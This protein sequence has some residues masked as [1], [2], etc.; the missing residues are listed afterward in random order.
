MVELFGDFSREPTEMAESVSS[1]LNLSIL[2][3]KAS[4]HAKRSIWQRKCS[5]GHQMPTVM[6][7]L[8][9]SAGAQP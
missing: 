5:R 6:N 2:L 4:H 7:T 8:F 1:A 9:G 3:K